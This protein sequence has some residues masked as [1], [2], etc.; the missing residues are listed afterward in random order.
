MWILFATIASHKGATALA[1]GS[2][3]QK[4]GATTRESIAF[5]GLF[6]LTAPV[7][8]LIGTTIEDVPNLVNLIFTSLSTGTF[9]YIGAYEVISEE[10]QSHHHD[11]TLDA[12]SAARQAAAKKTR[13]LKFAAIF[14]GMVSMSLAALIPHH[15]A[16]GHDHDH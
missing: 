13:Y 2:R 14:L 4:A 3:F 11:S 10:F 9:L 12:N 6:A 5:A 16:G 7:S 15:H 1:L 8:I